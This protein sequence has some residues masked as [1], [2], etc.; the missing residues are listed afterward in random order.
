MKTK[1]I[2]KTFLLSLFLLL[3][4]FSTPLAQGLG[5][6]D[7]PVVVGP[8]AGSC[9][10]GI[11]QGGEQ[12]EGQDAQACG[13]YACSQDCNCLAFCTTSSDCS[14]GAICSNNICTPEIIQGQI[15]F[16]GNQ[17]IDEGEQCE[18]GVAYGGGCSPNEY[19]SSCQCR[20]QWLP[21]ALI[22]FAISVS[23]I[24]FIYMGGI[25]FSSTELKTYATDELTQLIFTAFAIAA[26]FGMVAYIDSTLLPAFTI[27]STPEGEAPFEGTLQE[28]ALQTTGQMKA[29]FESNLQTSLDISKTIG[30]EGSKSGYCS[31][32]GLGYSIV[33]CSAINAIRS[34]VTNAATSLSLAVADFQ[35]VFSLLT[36]GKDYAFA[37]LLPI[38][39]FLRTFNF[40]RKVG[41]VMI[42]LAIGFY[43]VFPITVLFSEKILMGQIL[44]SDP[45]LYSYKNG[46][47]YAYPAYCDDPDGVI[48]H[49][50][51]CTQAELDAGDT[52]SGGQTEYLMLPN[53]MASATCDSF[54]FSYNN[55]QTRFITPLIGQAETEEGSG[56][57]IYNFEPLIFQ[58]YVRAIFATALN[59]TITLLF[60]QW[61]A[62]IL[63]S[64]IDVSSLMRISQ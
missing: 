32:L 3:S 6:I 54:D 17:R 43:M 8:G 33:S 30:K 11:I 29:Q 63:G 4:L 5:G 34:P 27:A 45:N 10:D 16:C 59:L 61:L 52:T 25:G 42:A 28:Y 14:D 62:A 23:L 7:G 57:F 37:I 20:P 51:A 26:L 15:P 39:I 13:L 22:A 49:M 55:I 1:T 60:I 47:P 36:F 41:G 50:G 40:T 19:C 44:D 9:G 21:N 18:A 24:A 64:Q 35:A 48:V 2:A 58:V 53:Y 31:V 12:C 38:G 46:L 56:I